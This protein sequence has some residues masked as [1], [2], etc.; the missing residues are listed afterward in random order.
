MQSLVRLLATLSLLLTLPTTPAAAQ[1]AEFAD[2]VD[3]TEVLLD[4]LVTDKKG[5]VIVGLEAEDFIVEESGERVEVQAATFY[6]NRRFVESAEATEKM[7]LEIEEV[8]VD[9]YFILFFHDTRRDDPSLTRNQIRAVK[10]AEQWISQELLPNDWVAVV[11]YD[12]KLRIHQDFTTDNGKLFAALEEVAKGKDPG[13][14]WPS[15]RDADAGPSLGP[16]LPQGRDLRKETTRIYSGLQVLAEA[17]GHVTGRKNVLFFSVGFGELNGFGAYVP[18]PRFYDDTM[19][20][21]NDNNLAIYAISLYESTRPRN[22]ALERLEGSLSLLAADTGGRFFSSF[23]N[24]ET[25]LR[26][27][28]EE[29]NGYY[30]LSYSSSSPA[31]DSGYRK[32][33]VS[34]EN[35][36]FVVKGREGY[37]YGHG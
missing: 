9:R 16:H 29:N 6:S 34:T 25:P 33:K 20:A 26:Q 13:A 30:L 12:V 5:N 8:P 19:Q 7:D 3:V 4:V 37:R 31:G 22:A 1:E 27:V 10:R 36:E 24:F 35:P 15:R 18:D 2:R 11:R 32:V 14:N 28:V 17:A 21:L 23:V